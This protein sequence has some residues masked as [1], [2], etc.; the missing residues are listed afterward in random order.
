MKRPPKIARPTSPINEGMSPL[1][2][3]LGTLNP[4]ALNN[5]LFQKST[6]NS[7]YD[8]VIELSMR[9]EQLKSENEML[10]A[11]LNEIINEPNANAF[12]QFEKWQQQF[13]QLLAKRDNQLEEFRKHVMSFRESTNPSFIEVM[14]KKTSPIQ[15]DTISYTLL[16]S[17]PQRGWFSS[18]DISKQ[19]YDLKDLIRTQENTIKVLNARLALFDQF[20]NKTQAKETINSLLNGEIPTPMQAA[21]PTRSVELRTTKKLMSSHLKELVDERKK[22]M[23]PKLEKK[24]QKR[25]ERAQGQ[26]AVKIQKIVRGFLARLQLKRMH[27]AAVTIQSFWRGCLV[28]LPK[29]K[30]SIKKQPSLF[31]IVKRRKSSMVIPPLES[32]S[33]AQLNNTQR[34]DKPDLSS[35]SNVSTKSS[36]RSNKAAISPANSKAE[37]SGKLSGR[38]ETSTN[39][40]LSTMSK[41]SS[42]SKD[43][44]TSIESKIS[45]ASKVSSSKDIEFMQ[46]V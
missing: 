37:L 27:K 5:P 2:M 22:I 15:F 30:K 45:K 35:R 17:N 6:N 32:A 13:Q 26:M 34:S 14:S 29:M 7:V 33:N 9:A 36:S 11:Q 24:M 28:R 38:S 16:V 46:N 12:C 25:N 8:E 42:V 41:I 18:D 4:H 31:K 10:K 23:A 39:S 3:T 40:K 1:K 44:K 19:N 21:A 43:S 20:K